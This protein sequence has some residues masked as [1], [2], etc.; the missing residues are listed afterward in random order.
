MT[1]FWLQRLRL[2]PLLALGPLCA[3]LVLGG[4]GWLG[5]EEAPPLPGTR[6]SI[7]AVDS[8]AEPDP[9]L[10]DLRV[11]LPAPY[12]NDAWPQ[13]GGYSDH[14]MHH[15]K[16]ADTL[17]RA[18]SADIG[19]GSGS[20]RRLLSGPVVAEGRVYTMD[21]DFEIRAFDAETGRRIWDFEPE[22]PD[23]DD[24]AFGGGIAY[25]DRMIFVT[26][27]YARVFALNAATGELIWEE[28]MPGPSRAAPSIAD[29]KVLAMSIDN[30]VT[31]YDAD[32]GE[33]LWF[34]AGFAETAGL[35]G[36]ASAAV[37]DRTAIVPYSS[38]EI[39]SLRL[40]TGRPNW[41][42]SLV[43][44][45]RVDALASLSDIRGRPVVDRGI[46]YAISHAGRMVAFD[47]AS[48]ARAWD[49]RIGGIQTPWIAGEF[50]YLVTLDQTVLALTRRGGRVRWA[51]PLPNYEDP[52]DLEDPITWAGPV[53]VSDR[54]LI[55]NSIGE[56]WSI[57]PY[58][59]RPLGRIDVGGPVYVPPVVANGT[60]YVQTDDG[61]L[62]AYR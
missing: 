53:L 31:A 13:G 8:D 12:F 20:G 52:E 37:T 40:S 35:L 33:E 2:R 41:S 39:F 15:L 55:G 58:D 57:S 21:S 34:H 54:L 46:V 27:G 42:D 5:D 56:L 17:S 10:S 48:G 45:R 6:V 43:S 26:T 7:M 60:V 51:T 47:L 50:L 25:A 19:S 11:K 4:C 1:G 28:R 38:G 14:A 62:I 3:G 18:W 24:E 29:G 59:G 32:T 16:A 30:R 22:I 61:D 23:E 36:G 9:R 49:R 44:V